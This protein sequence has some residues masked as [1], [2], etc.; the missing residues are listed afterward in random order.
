MHL[1]HTIGFIA[2]TMI[3]STGSLAGQVPA[4]VLRAARVF[5]GTTMHTGWEVVV[6]GDTIAAAGPSAS[7]SVPR[8]ARIVDLGDVTLMPGMIEGHGHFLLHP[9]NERS[10]NDQ[11][12]YEPLALRIARATV[13]MHVTLLAGITTER[14]LGTEGAMYADVGLRDAVRQGIIPGPRMIVVTRAIVGRGS[15][16]VRGAPEWDLPYGAEQAGNPDELESVERDQIGRGADWVKI[17]GDYR[18]GP[19]GEAAPTFTE[20]ELQRAV[21]VAASSGRYVAVHATTVE[22]MRRA[23]LA[24]VATIEHGDAG[25]PE[26][27]KLLAEHG[28]GYCPTVSATEAYAEYRGWKKGVDPD[29]PSVVQKKA[30]FRAALASGVKIC[31]GGDVGVFSHGTNVRELETMVEYGMSPLEAVISA[32]SRNAEIFHLADRGRVAPGLLADLIA[33]PGDPTRDVHVLR[34][35]RFVMQGGAVVKK[36]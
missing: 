25:T 27:F 11:V 24:G 22:G 4:T 5:D 23:A 35:V 19:H 10:W 2:L 13:A 29:P 14:D 31:F 18:W 32:T 7:V 16:G 8:G 15:Y 3:T 1:G 6:A 20:D 34:D 9:Y 36:E 12:L 30:A 17:Y 33:V 28:V 21:L 26:V